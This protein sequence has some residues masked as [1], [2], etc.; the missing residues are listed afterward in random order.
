MNMPQKD[1]DQLI[2]G[3]SNLWANQQLDVQVYEKAAEVVERAR[4]GSVDQGRL[5]MIE[6]LLEGSVKPEVFIVA[7]KAL[8]RSKFGGSAIQESDPGPIR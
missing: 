6:Y 3:L 8:E 7:W 2:T 1:F 5:R 4:Q